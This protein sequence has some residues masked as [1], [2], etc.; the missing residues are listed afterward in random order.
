MKKIRRQPVKVQRTAA[1]SSIRLVFQALYYR[2]EFARRN[3]EVYVSQ[4]SL[5]K[6]LGLP[7]DLFRKFVHPDG[8]LTDILRNKIESSRGRAKG[9]RRK[10]LK[11]YLSELAIVPMCWKW[12][13]EGTFFPKQYFEEVQMNYLSCIKAYKSLL[14][15]E[16]YAMAVLGVGHPVMTPLMPL[17]IVGK[18]RSVVISQLELDKY[19]A[20]MFLDYSAPKQTIDAYSNLYSIDNEM[21]AHRKDLLSV[22]DPKS[23]P[24]DARIE[25]IKPFVLDQHLAV[26]DVA[27]HW[28]R[29]RRFADKADYY[30]RIELGRPISR[31]EAYEN[32]DPISEWFSQKLKL[33]KPYEKGYREII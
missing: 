27:R 22:E 4:D 14:G 5:A 18:N 9:S 15:F 17:T 3:K 20:P 30:A 32:S 28:E 21:F 2:H 31:Q 19:T 6:D 29:K 33:A 24:E 23:D 7:E 25:R 11:Q 1:E 10:A 13:D 26:L 16:A 8:F 12:G